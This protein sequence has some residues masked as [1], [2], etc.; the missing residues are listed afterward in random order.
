MTQSYVFTNRLPKGS[1]VNLKIVEFGGI[2][3]SSL[4]GPDTYLRRMGDRFQAT[5]K[6]PA[7]EKN[8]AGDWIGNRAFGYAA[9]GHMRIDIPQF[10]SVEEAGKPQVILG[11]GTGGTYIYLDPNTS[12]L[13][14]NGQLFTYYDANLDFYFLHM[15]TAFEVNN[16]GF[17]MIRVAPPL[18]GDPIGLYLDFG[19]PVIQGFVSGLDINISQKRFVAQEFTITEGR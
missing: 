6:L 9:L 17:P 13:Y 2:Q 7:T 5:I 3:R 18:R 15:V 1:E 14:R 8:I 4:G 10:C 11:A 16:N 19:L 12:G